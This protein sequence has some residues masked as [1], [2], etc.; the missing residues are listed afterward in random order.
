MG[1]QE[2]LSNMARN[3]LLAGGLHPVKYLAVIDGKPM[4]RDLAIE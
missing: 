4:E 1:L 2:T 3:G